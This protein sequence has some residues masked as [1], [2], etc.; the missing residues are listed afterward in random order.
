MGPSRFGLTAQ[1]GN[2]GFDAAMLAALA[3]GKALAAD[4]TR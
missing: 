1:L 4:K 2:A 3:G